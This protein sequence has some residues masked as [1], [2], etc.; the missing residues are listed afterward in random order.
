MPAMDQAS[1]RPRM[2]RAANQTGREY[3]QVLPLNPSPCQLPSLL[4]TPCLRPRA[5]LLRHWKLP[6][7]HG[8]FDWKSPSSSPDPSLS[9]LRQAFSAQPVSSQEPHDIGPPNRSALRPEIQQPP[10]AV[11]SPPPR[12]A[13]LRRRSV[14]GGWR[15][16][17]ALRR[18]G[19]RTL[20]FRGCGF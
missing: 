13:L 8:Y 3:F 15:S 16:L 20:R 12:D 7:V 6:G 9:L 19:C 11:A 4:G 10:R 14:Q 1:L 2:P 17:N 5:R 18:F